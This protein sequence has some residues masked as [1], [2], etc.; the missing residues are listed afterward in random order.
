[1]L[2]VPDYDII[3]LDLDGTLTD[4]TEEMISSAHY[5]LKQF[6][7]KERDP[8]RMQLFTTVPL[9][10]CFEDHF[11]LTRE[12]AD[13]AFIHY[14]YYAGTF[15]V[16]KNKPYDGVP[17]MLKTLHDQGKT[18]CIATA[19][20]TKNVEQILK[21]L[22]LDHYFTIILGASEDESRRTKKMV[23]FDLLCDLPD[24]TDKNVIMVGDRVVDLIGARDNAIDSMAVTY[25]AEPVEDLMKLNPTYVANNVSEMAAILIGDEKP[26]DLQPSNS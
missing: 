25:G 23:I 15:G 9:L 18:L 16:S 12:Q 6:G 8:E 19:R 7:I 20:Q 2:S 24:H 5:A 4:P 1:M 17:E 21:A 3:L 10:H 14:W 22:N 26:A 11:G 13:Q